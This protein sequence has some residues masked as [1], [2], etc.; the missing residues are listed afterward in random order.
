MRYAVI[1]FVK[2]WQN[3]SIICEL[4]HHHITFYTILHFQHFTSSSKQQQNT[5]TNIF[6]SLHFVLTKHHSF[7]LTSTAIVSSSC[8]IN[9]VASLDLRHRTLKRIY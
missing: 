5:Y 9:S 3:F 8:Q 1:I 4:S 7:I 2:S 6:I